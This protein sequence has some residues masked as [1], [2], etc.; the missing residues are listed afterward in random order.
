[1]K[2]FVAG[3][4]ELTREVHL[5]FLFSRYG[6]VKSVYILRDPETRHSLGYA[7]VE[8]SCDREAERAIRH[9]NGRLWRNGQLR[10]FKWRRRSNAA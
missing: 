10:V 5:R 3:F 9:L 1:M 7:A 8:M 2:I 6:L 4:D